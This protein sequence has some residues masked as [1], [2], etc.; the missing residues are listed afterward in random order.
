MSWEKEQST[1][2]IKL[3]AACAR[4]GD[5]WHTCTL[6][7]EL[8]DREFDNNLWCEPDWT[9]FTAWGERYV[10]F[11]CLYDCNVWVGY[12]PRNPCDEETNMQGVVCIDGTRFYEP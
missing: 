1:W 3:D 7:E 10:F 8:L 12:V 5:P 11:P 4:A 6:H 2:R 9:G